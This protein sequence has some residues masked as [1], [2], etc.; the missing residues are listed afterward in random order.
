MDSKLGNDEVKEMRGFMDSETVVRLVGWKVTN[1]RLQ[2]KDEKIR[3]GRQGK[4]EGD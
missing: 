1:S 4:E 2:S 3:H